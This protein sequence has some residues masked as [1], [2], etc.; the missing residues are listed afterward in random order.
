MNCD[1]KLTFFYEIYNDLI[2][3]KNENKYI[4]SLMDITKNIGLIEFI[5]IENVK[6]LIL[7]LKN[8]NLI[9]SY[10][11][12]LL[13]YVK[14]ELVSE[15]LKFFSD[16]SLFQNDNENQIEELCIKYVFDKFDQLKKEET[17]IDSFKIIQ[18]N[19]KQQI[20]KN[21]SFNFNDLVEINISKNNPES[22]WYFETR[23]DIFN[24]FT[25]LKNYFGIDKLKVYKIKEVTYGEIYEMTFKKLVKFHNKIILKIKKNIKKAIDLC[26]S[27]IQVEKTF[28]SSLIKLKN[29]NSENNLNNFILSDELND[30]N[31]QDSDSDIDYVDNLFKQI[32]N[33]NQFSDLS[34]I[35]D[36]SETSETSDM[37]DENNLNNLDN[38]SEFINTSD[39]DF[40]PFAEIFKT[41]QNYEPIELQKNT[42]SFEEFN[43]FNE[44]DKLFS[45][46]DFD[47][48]ILD[49]EL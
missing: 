29:E 12:T 24:R 25:Y 41:S 48:D 19:S 35:S 3:T 15:L 8:K 47:D 9:Y 7:E 26:N 27:F 42:I 38:L 22:S 46:P 4:I 5:N 2:E 36:M 44:I 18:I 37:S 17:F 31:T 43:K 6:N 10:K 30:E 14:S 32:E 39:K 23:I 13:I 40:E 20:Q 16:F 11:L 28:I 33:E 1:K 49:E 21:N 34:E 45:G